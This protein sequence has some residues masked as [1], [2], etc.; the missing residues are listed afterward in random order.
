MAQTPVTLNN[1]KGQSS[2]SELSHMQ[3]IHICAAQQ[4][5]R[6]QLARSHLAVPQRQLGFLFVKILSTANKTKKMHGYVTHPN[7]HAK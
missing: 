4:F 7:Q 1:L 3:V 6:F 5:T 2:V